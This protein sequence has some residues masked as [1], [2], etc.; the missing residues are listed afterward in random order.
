M[1]GP[2][3]PIFLGTMHHRAVGFRTSGCWRELTGDSGI[4]TLTLPAVPALVL[5]PRP[6]G[7]RRARTRSA[8]FPQGRHFRNWESIS[9]EENGLD[10]L[11]RRPRC[12]C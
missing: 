10:G 4:G 3:F 1:P 5:Q 8:H 2:S 7:T 12:G 11:R 6:S 9:L